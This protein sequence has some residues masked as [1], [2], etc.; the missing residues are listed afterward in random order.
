MNAINP[1]QV[2][3]FLPVGLLIGSLYF[4]LLWYSVR[5]F[6]AQSSVARMVPLSLLRMAVAVV[7]FWFIA[8]QGVV[9]VLSA[10]AGFLIGR[11]IVKHWVMRVYGD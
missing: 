5:S 6:A 9:P 4:L 10:L 1:Y 8:Q 7:C 3:L 11:L 2:A